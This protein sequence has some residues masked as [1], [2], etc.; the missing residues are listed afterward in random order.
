MTALK[1]K[2]QIWKLFQA[3]LVDQI[4]ERGSSEL[5]CDCFLDAQ[6]TLLFRISTLT[7]NLFLHE[8]QKELNPNNLPTAKSN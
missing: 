6:L 4:V 3:R 2:N 8:D 1:S 7:F 5:L